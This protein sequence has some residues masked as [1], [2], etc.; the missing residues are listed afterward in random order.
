MVSRLG[1]V[2]EGEDRS[3]EKMRT[4]QRSERTRGGGAEL[5]S[6]ELGFFF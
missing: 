3:V 2:V 4:Q 1:V 6:S 5:G